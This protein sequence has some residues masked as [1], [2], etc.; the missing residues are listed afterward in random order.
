MKKGEGIVL[1][2]EVKAVLFDLDGVLVDSE[3]A[4]FHVINDTCRHFGFKPVTKERF[5]KRFGAPIEDD[6][7]FLFRG[8]TIKEVEAFYN[9]DFGKRAKYFK[10]FP[11]SRIALKKLKNKKVKL[12][13][14]SNSTTLIVSAILGNFRLKKYFDVVVAMDDVKRGKPAPDMVIKACR[15]LKVSTKNTILI[16]DTK[17]DMIA[18]KSAGCVTVGYGVKGDYRIDNLEEIGRFI[19]V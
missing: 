4:W 6:V 2:K 12:G 3:K 15:L 9:A 10:L 17:N 19:Y 14:I 18:G 11:Q 13:L 8:R 1:K 7:K 5:E 16:G